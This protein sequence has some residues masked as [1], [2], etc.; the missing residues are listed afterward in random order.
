MNERDKG[1]I[2]SLRRFRV[3][4]RDQIIKLHFTNV[5]DQINSCNKVLK[6]LNRDGHVEVDLSSR[7]YNYFPSPCTMRKDSQKIPHFKEIANF[8]LSLLP[9]KTPN[10]FEVEFKSGQKG[11][12]EPDIFMLWNG[13]PFFVEIQRNYYSSKVMDAKMK[14]YADYFQEGTWREWTQHFPYIWILSE[15]KYNMDFKPLRVFQT[16]T[17]A[18]FVDAYLKKQK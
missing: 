16:K 1:I 11:S 18:E 8:Y 13:V 10:Q 4:D 3:L 15:H 2:E 5:K 17:A 9:F 6:R 7:P 14:R 12:I